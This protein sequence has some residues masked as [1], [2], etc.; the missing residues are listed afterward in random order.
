MSIQNSG[1][2]NHKSLIVDVNKGMI[3]S[4]KCTTKAFSGWAAP[5]PAWKTHIAPR[6]LSWI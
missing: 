6:L 4:S 1:C 3:F 2:A 5:E